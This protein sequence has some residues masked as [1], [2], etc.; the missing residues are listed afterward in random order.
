MI[1]ISYDKNPNLY[2]DYEDCLNFLGCTR[3]ENFSY[4]IEPVNFHLYSEI[5]N[6]KELL[7]LKSFFATQNLNHC[8]LILWS[9]YYIQDNPLLAPFKNRIEFKIYDPVFLSR[10][11]IMEGHTGILEATDT[12][13]YLKSG[14]LRFLAT[15]VMGGIWY[16]MDMV[17]L[18][19]LVPIMDQEFAY[20]WGSET[21]FAGFGPCAAF[22]NIHKNSEHSIMC[23]EE[24][25]KSPI[26]PDTVCFDHQLLA[27]VYRRRPFTVFPSVFFNTEWQINKKHPGK[28]T[29]IES[30]W[31]EKNEYSD[32]LFPEAFAWHWHNSS[33][34]NLEVKEGSKFFRI[35]KIMDKLLK[36]KGII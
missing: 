11:T 30:G 21:D 32:N 4:P 25:I 19:N 16:D 22:M 26:I 6:E 34:K 7:S 18:R 17:L 10:G 9:D 33:K 28:G 3:E 15:H 12:R 27:K 1:D 14:V 35:S 20:M 24:L 2:T 36:N 31:F 13:H 8:H 5:R 23:L 29:A